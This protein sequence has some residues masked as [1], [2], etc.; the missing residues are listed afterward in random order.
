MTHPAHVK[1]RALALLLTGERVMNV[2][3]MTGVPKQTVSRWRRDS[4][5]ILRQAMR[6]CPELRAA[7]ASIRSIFVSLSQVDRDIKK[8][9]GR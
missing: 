7:V 5:S 9:Q 4:D 8:R 2:S 3:R 1:A 6:S